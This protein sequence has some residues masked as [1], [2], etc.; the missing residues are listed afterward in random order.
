MRYLNVLY[1]AMEYISVYKQALYRINWVQ[2]HIF[3]TIVIRV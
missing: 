1:N 2:H 3:W